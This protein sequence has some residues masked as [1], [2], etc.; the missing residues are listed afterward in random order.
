MLDEYTIKVQSKAEFDSYPKQYFVN[1]LSSTRT[2]HKLN[3]CYYGKMCNAFIP[4]DSYEDIIQFENL[5]M[6]MTPF[7]RCT[8]CFSAHSIN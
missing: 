5:H 3:G 7:K 2:I 1:M 6:P 4:F 8:K